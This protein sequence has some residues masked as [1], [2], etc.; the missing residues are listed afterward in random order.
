M[1][2]QLVFDNRKP[3]DETYPQFKEAEFRGDFNLFVNDGDYIVNRDGNVM[4]VTS[5]NMKYKENG[6]DFNKPFLR[7]RYIDN[8]DDSLEY[9]NQIR[10]ATKEEIATSK[11]WKKT[12]TPFRVDTSGQLLLV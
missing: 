1:K 11:D 6:L 4:I 2:Y 5:G 3:D 10:F 12:G 9:A 8:V 7:A